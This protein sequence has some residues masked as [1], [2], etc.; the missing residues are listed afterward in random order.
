[1]IVGVLA[2]SVDWIIAGKNTVE[3]SKDNNH[4][5]LLER[6]LVRIQTGSIGVRIMM[7][8]SELSGMSS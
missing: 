1:M 7:N 5:Y 8:V 2:S 6:D 3:S 4:W